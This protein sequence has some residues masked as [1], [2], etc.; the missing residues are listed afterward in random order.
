[1]KRIALSLALLLTF[2][3]I[4]TAQCQPRLIARSAMVKRPL[5]DVY[6]T[7]KKYFSQP[8][9]S[10]FQLTSFDLG[11]SKATLVAKMQNIDAKNWAADAACKVGI[12]EMIYH[13]DNGAVTVTVTMQGVGNEA[14][15]VSVLADF[16]GTYSLASA[17][18]VVPCISTGV[19]EQQ[20]L[21]VAGAQPAPEATATQ[22]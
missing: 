11:V 4:P 19:L 8:E 13:L 1:M 18:S 7:L 10:R 3:A 2:A 20:L 22:G 15:F 12:A 14:T 21:T 6:G 17:S 9:L 16:Q 5:A